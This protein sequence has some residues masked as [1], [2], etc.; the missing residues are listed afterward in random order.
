[1]NEINQILIPLSVVLY[2]LISC[3]FDAFE[4]LSGGRVRKIEEK[5]P[6]LVTI[7]V[8]NFDDTSY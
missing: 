6:E 5:N 8:F 3:V 1:M 7:N 4:D 2:M